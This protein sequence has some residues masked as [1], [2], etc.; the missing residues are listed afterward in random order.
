LSARR[1][2]HE[3]TIVR[4]HATRVYCAPADAPAR[5]RALVAQFE[6]ASDAGSYAALDASFDGGAPTSEPVAPHAAKFGGEQKA[7]FVALFWKLLRA[8]AYPASGKSF[9]EARWTLRPTKGLGVVMDAHPEA[10]DLETE[11]TSHRRRIDGVL[12]PRDVSFDYQSQFGRIIARKG[13]PGLFALLE[14]RAS[15]RSSRSFCPSSTC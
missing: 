13:V 15:R 11:I 4:N 1:V 10:D 7:R 9:L 5:T 8:I 6:A 2:P 14:R 12:R 3:E